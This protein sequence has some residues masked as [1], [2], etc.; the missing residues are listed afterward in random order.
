MEINGFK[1]IAP[2]TCD[3]SGFSKWGFARKDGED[4][5][6]KEFLSPIY[7]VRRD[8][9]SEE[10]I[11]EKV[12]ICKDFEREKSR[13]YR[14]ISE[15]SNGNIVPICQF[16]RFSSHYYIVTDRINAK[17]LTIGEISSM[18]SGQKLIISK[19]I[20]YS[21]G[22]LHSKGIVHGDIKPDNLLFSKSPSGIYTAKLIDFDSSF[23]ADN[24][25][26]NNEDFQG[27]LIY[28]A[29]ESYLYMADGETKITTKADVFALGVMLH[30]F[31]SGELPYIDK[32]EYDYMFEAVLSG[33]KLGISMEIPTSVAVIIKQMIEKNPDDRPAL[34]SVFMALAKINFE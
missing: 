30:L 32:N 6:I 3:K 4:Y 33:E 5:F 24:P 11:I 34:S 21:L 26:K 31:W 10:Q 9:L 15:C 25:P 2:L 19:I 1:L 23:F 14:A 18:D 12:K 27:D 13:L 29:P 16:F 7:P 17:S 20:A 28:L 8:V 22:L